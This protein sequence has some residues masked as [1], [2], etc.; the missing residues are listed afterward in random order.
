MLI[1]PNTFSCQTEF[2]FRLFW[3]DRKGK[4]QGFKWKAMGYPSETL[5]LKILLLLGNVNK[6]I[7]VHTY[8]VSS[9]IVLVSDGRTMYFHSRS[10]P[11]FE[12]WK[13]LFYEVPCPENVVSE[14]FVVSLGSNGEEGFRLKETF[15]LSGPHSEIRPA[16]FTSH[17]AR[18]NWEI[19]WSMLSTETT[20][21][22]QQECVILM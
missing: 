20:E 15:K 2:L 10:L 22:C 6:S 8:F 1:I 16:W 7:L 9:A 17:S 13:S 11:I 14:I 4:K 19:K 3:N 12:M 18:T 21:I 5:C